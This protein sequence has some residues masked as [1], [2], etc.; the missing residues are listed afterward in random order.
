MAL[1]P[2]WGGSSFPRMAAAQV[3]VLRGPTPAHTPP[4]PPPFRDGQPPPLKVPDLPQQVYTGSDTASRIFHSPSIPPPSSCFS[5]KIASNG[6]DGGSTEEGNIH[7]WE[8]PRPGGRLILPSS[9]CPLPLPRPISLSSQG[10]GRNIPSHFLAP[11]PS[12]LARIA[13]PLERLFAELFSRVAPS[14]APSPAA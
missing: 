4:P 9:S 2:S 5:F 11:L 6:W 1:P 12:C 13:G 14:W 10:T 3:S 8:A 7:C